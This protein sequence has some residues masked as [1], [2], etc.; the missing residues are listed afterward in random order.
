MRQVKGPD[1]NHPRLRKLCVTKSPCES[2]SGR[3]HRQSETVAHAQFRHENAGLG[4]LSLD[5]LP[6]YAIPTFGYFILA[7]ATKRYRLLDSDWFVGM[8]A[9]T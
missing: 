3:V 2:L 4:R 1:K 9:V 6:Y 7:S 8:L 5:L